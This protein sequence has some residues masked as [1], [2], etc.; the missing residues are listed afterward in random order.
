MALREKKEKLKG[1]L[2]LS[3][4]LAKANFKLRNEGSYLGVFWY[5]LEPLLIFIVILGIHSAFSFSSVENYPLYLLLG[6]IMFNFFSGTT[7]RATGFITG[8]GNLIKQVKIDQETVVFSQVVEASFSHVFEFILFA[9][10]VLFF[11]GS[12]LWVLFYPLIFLFYFLFILGFSFL[13]AA[14]GVY[15]NDLSNVWRVVTRVLFFF[16]P[17]FHSAS[18]GTF[19]HTANFFNPLFYFIEIGRSLMVY[20]MI[21]ELWMVYLIIG[22]SVFFFVLGIFVFEKYKYRFAEMV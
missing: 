11:G 15:I 1:I 17:L 22:I 2:G 8:S 3:Y 18:E 20:N 7:S 19:L 16:T 9:G 4:Q 6:L 5:L 21:P 12:I 10:F 13:L 14:L